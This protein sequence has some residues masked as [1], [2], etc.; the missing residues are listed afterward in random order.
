MN[1]VLVETFLAVFPCVHKQ[2]EEGH[3]WNYWN[4]Y[5]DLKPKFEKEVS[6]LLKELGFNEETE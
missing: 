4:D 2:L 5:A 1:H 3:A 6:A